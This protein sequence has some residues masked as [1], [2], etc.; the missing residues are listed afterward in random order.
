MLALQQEHQRILL[1]EQLIVIL[2][3]LKRLVST[4]IMLLRTRFIHWTKQQIPVA[5]G[6]SRPSQHAADKVIAVLIL[7]G[8]HP[9]Y[10][11]VA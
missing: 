9:D 11:W 2:S 6:L 10:Q 3:R 4:H 8:L 1:K 5:C 7:G